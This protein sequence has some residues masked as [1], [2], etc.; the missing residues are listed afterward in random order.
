MILIIS[1]NGGI[2]KDYGTILNAEKH[3]NPNAET[4]KSSSIKSGNLESRKQKSPIQK[5]TN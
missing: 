2:G 4:L 1:G 3:D 5:L